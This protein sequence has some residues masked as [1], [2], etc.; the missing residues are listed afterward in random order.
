[1]SLAESLE[2]RGL[3]LLVGDLSGGNGQLSSLD[4]D[5]ILVS[6][7]S[8]AG[9]L[10]SGCVTLLSLLTRLGEDNQLR[11]ELLNAVHVGGHR[12]LVLVSTSLVNGDTD[13]AG[14]LHGNTGL[15]QLSGSETTAL[16]NLEVVSLSGGNHNR[17]QQT[18]NRS[19]ENLGGLGLTRESSSLLTSRLVEP[20]SDIGVV[21][22]EGINIFEQETTY[23]L[24]VVRVGQDV[25]TDDHC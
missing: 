11:L 19:G 2:H 9:Q 12:N 4:G 22:K 17:S 18:G 8:N 10:I 25:V 23:V 15:L 16:A 14:E 6:V 3:S 1:V 21:L 7:L 5:D 24:L 13:G 20:G